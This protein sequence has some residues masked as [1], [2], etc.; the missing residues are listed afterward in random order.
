MLRDEF[1]VAGYSWKEIPFPHPFKEP[2]QVELVK[3]SGSIYTAHLVG[4]VTVHKFVV[5]SH[6]KTSST[7][8]ARYRW[9]ATGT[10]LS[11]VEDKKAA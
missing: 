4:E 2:P 1:V 11:R 6:P 10:L 7:Y 3:L 5:I 9:I 8:D